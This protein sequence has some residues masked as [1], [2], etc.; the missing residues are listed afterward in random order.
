MVVKLY[1]S[2]VSSEGFDSLFAMRRIVCDRRGRRTV[3]V[4]DEPVPPVKHVFEKQAY[5]LKTEPISL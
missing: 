4:Y 1:I 2:G 5:G 3:E